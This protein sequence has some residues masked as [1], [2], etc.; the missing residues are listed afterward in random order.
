MRRINKG[1]PYKPFTD[2][3]ATNHPI[4]WAALDQTIRRDS[5]NCMIQNEQECL[6]GY[7]ELPIDLDNSHIDHFKKRSLFP[8]LTFEWSN[9]VAAIIDDE[10]GARYKDN[11]HSITI[12]EYNEIFN[13]VLENPERYFSYTE[14]GEIVTKEGIPNDE[15]EKAEKTITVFNLRHRSLKSR[16]YAIIQMIKSCKE[17][18]TK[19]ELL[20]LFNGQGFKSVVE[21]FT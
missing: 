4:D 14:W 2:F 19:E 9:L 21:L 3:V 11:T 7:T 16:R 17:Q 20:Q 12:A 18:F 1:T 10:F 6:C 5:R 8:R 15:K 13:P